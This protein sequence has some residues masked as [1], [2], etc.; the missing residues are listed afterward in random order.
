MNDF[1][2]GEKL[3]DWKEK[4]NEKGFRNSIGKCTKKKKNNLN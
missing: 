3:R 2:C 1:V 4:R